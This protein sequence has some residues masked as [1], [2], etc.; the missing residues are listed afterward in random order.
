MSYVSMTIC[1]ADGR[2]ITGEQGAVLLRECPR[3]AELSSG[4][5]ATTRAEDGSR[6]A[7]RNP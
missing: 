5:C 7:R 2:A 4:R 1:A 3:R 6:A